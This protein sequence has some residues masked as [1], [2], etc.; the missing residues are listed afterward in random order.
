MLPGIG[1]AE[2]EDEMV[3]G[4]PAVPALKTP[5]IVPRNEKLFML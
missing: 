5:F 2:S 4:F 1:T 3:M